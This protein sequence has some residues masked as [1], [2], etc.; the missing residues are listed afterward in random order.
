MLSWITGNL[1]SILVTLILVL[2]VDWAILSIIKDKKRGS[3]C[4]GGSCAHCNMCA[5]AKSKTE[6]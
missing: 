4:C 3:S 6:K 2:I 5:G 1:G